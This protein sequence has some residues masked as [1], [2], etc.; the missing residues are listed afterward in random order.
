M[1]V[2]V[3]GELCEGGITV[4]GHRMWGLCCKVLIIS[5]RQSIPGIALHRV[6]MLFAGGKRW[7]APLL[8]ARMARATLRPY[9][10]QDRCN[11]N[12]GE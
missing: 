6:K 12:Q 5:P 9:A 4:E 2:V 3:D 7:K 10:E 11:V 8:P 1:K